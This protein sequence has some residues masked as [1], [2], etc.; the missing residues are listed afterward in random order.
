MA[1]HQGWVVTKYLYFMSDLQYN[2]TFTRNELCFTVLLAVLLLLLQLLFLFTVLLC[3]K[4][5][6]KN[7]LDC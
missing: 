2:V 5:F 4:V 3:N 6:S 7:V 1:Y